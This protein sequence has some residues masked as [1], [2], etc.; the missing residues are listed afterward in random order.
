MRSQIGVRQYRLNTDEMFRGTH[1][2]HTILNNDDD[3]DNNNN[4]NNNNNNIVVHYTWSIEWICLASYFFMLNCYYVHFSVYTDSY[5]ARQA[6]IHGNH[7]N[8]NGNISWELPCPWCPWCP[9]MLG[10]YVM[11][12]NPI[13]A[14][15]RIHS[16]E[17][18]QLTES[19]LFRINDMFAL[20]T[21]MS[22][23]VCVCHTY[24]DRLGNYHCK[25]NTPRCPPLSQ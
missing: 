9:C 18:K 7:G 25:P 17:K 3:D 14:R 13:T 5:A 8:P 4:N 6:I 20:I 10:S 16:I 15:S 2:K 21:A 11:P 22:V 1:N 23:Y 12:D 24:V 19:C